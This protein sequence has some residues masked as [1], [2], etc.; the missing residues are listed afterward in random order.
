MNS[1]TP[2]KKE[3]N[4]NHGGQLRKA[5]QRYDI[6]LEKWLD[7]STGINPNGY[8]VKTVPPEVWQRLPEEHDGLE[9]AAAKYYQSDNFVAVPGS[10]WIIQKL[11][12][13]IQSN[14]SS[15]SV[16]VFEPSYFEHSKAWQEAG[17][18]LVVIPHDASIEFIDQLLPELDALILITPNNPTGR[19][20]HREVLLNWLS[21]LQANKG[22]LVVDEAFADTDPNHSLVPLFSE[23]NTEQETL[24][25]KGLVVL[26]SLG[27]FFGL[28][29]VRL[30]FVFAD[31][32]LLNRVTKE[33]GPWAIAN[34]S[35]WVAKQALSD[36]RWH[37][38]QRLGLGFDRL[39]LM[40]LL[41][42]YGLEANGSCSL[43]VWVKT[44]KSNIVFEHLAKAGILVR[45]FEPNSR[46]Q[47]GSL[48]FGLPAN[49]EEF[50]RLEK[51]LA[52]FE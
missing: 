29:G 4:Q 33:L 1:K 41:D 43:F 7:L 8:P 25:L 19:H 23:G 13:L 10:Q 45:Q 2:L 9:E 5:A 22:H 28:A 16:G 48:R 50:A 49:K 51:A 32:A 3:T 34:P 20:F 36:Q 38:E 21:I 52:Q 12:Q 31:A 39:T 18:R 26:R 47:I 44:A 14:K 40:T 11:P 15:L 6:P 46:D 37:H 35:R 27:K 17:H 42:K 30:G 24:T